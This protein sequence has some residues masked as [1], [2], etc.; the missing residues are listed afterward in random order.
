[1][2]NFWENSELKREEVEKNISQI[3][4]ITKTYIFTKKLKV[5]LIFSLDD[6]SVMKRNT[7]KIIKVNVYDYDSI[8]ALATERKKPISISIEDFYNYYNTVMN[9]R[10][11]FLSEQMRK[12]R[13]SKCQKSPSETETE[14]DDSGLC[15][16]CNENNV[17][18]SLPCT[19]FFCEKCI[20]TWLVKSESCP[21]CRYKLKLNKKSPSGVSGA[22]SWNIIEDDFDE[23]QIEKEY[24]KTLRNLTKK[25]FF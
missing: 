13:K 21:I 17:N 9:S 15:P 11:M 2:G 12:R 20:K 22:Q 8:K 19:H 16:I 23:G 24:E 5:Y 6:D 18:L 10:A 7:R 4:E 14:T 25:L 3:N 1:M